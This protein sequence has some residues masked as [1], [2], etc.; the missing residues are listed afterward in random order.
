MKYRTESDSLGKLQIPQDKYYGVQTQRAV[1]NFKISGIKM[2]E[3]PKLVRALAAVKEAAAISN[4]EL[5]QLDPE[6]ARAIITACQEV[7][8]GEFYDHFPVDMIQGG[9]GTSANMNANEV[10]CNRALE[11][12]KHKKGEY[13]FIHPNNHVNLSQSTNDVYPTAAKISI[14]WMSDDIVN[15]IVALRDAFFAK[16]DEFKNVIK[17]GRTQ[18]QDAVPMTL[19]QEFKAFGVT[20]NED[21]VQLK[22]ALNLCYIINMGATAIGTGINT[23]P[24]YTEMVCKHLAKIT[25]L[26]LTSAE[27]LVEAT[28]DTGAFVAVSSVL[29]KIA[30]KL[31]KVCNDLRLLSSGPKAGLHDITLPAMQPGS[32]IMPAKVNPVI[33]EVVNQVCFQVIGYDL[34]ITLAASGGQMQLN[35]FEPLMVYN[36]FESII[37]LQRA[38]NTLR[39]KCVNGIVANVEHCATE[40]MRSAGLLTA[41]VPYIGYEEAAKIAKKVQNSDKTV[42]ELIKEA[43]LLSEEEIATILLPANMIS[44]Q[45]ELKIATKLRLKAKKTVKKRRSRR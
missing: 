23:L 2:S 27:D 21:I 22:N 34:A 41:F 45:A 18:L 31:T 40:V 43:K 24:G 13:Q 44:P 9:A 42:Y 8:G 14:A 37:L 28:S 7:Y 1:E 15:A 36:I 19:G 5:G 26:P 32:S 25:N 20:I 16:A 29:K 3:R 17:M 12:I 39:E 10:I 35:A 33:P 6:I 4:M 11:L 38:C 30:V